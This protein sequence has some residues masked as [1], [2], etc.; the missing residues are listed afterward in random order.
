MDSHNYNLTNITVNSMVMDQSS[1]ITVGRRL[2]ITAQTANIT[3]IYSAVANSAIMN[4]DSTEKTYASIL[5]DQFLDLVGILQADYV[6]LISRQDISIAGI[7][8]PLYAKASTC[9]LNNQTKLLSFVDP[10]LNKG[11][12]PMTEQDI[13]QNIENFNS[14]AVNIT[15][16]TAPEFIWNSFTTS[17][18]ALGSLTI[19]DKS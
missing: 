11:E 16:E 7:G 17:I 3:R 2:N 18:L 15:F 13:I 9:I 12:D 1:T 6:S 8:Y 5:T 14:S 19:Q 4:K 10:A